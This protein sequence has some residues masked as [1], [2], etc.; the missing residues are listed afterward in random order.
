[1]GLI[2][3]AERARAERDAT[4]VDTSADM[5]RLELMGLSRRLTEESGVSDLPPT[6]VSQAAADHASTKVIN[7]NA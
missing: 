4:A 1:M 5:V 3:R 7:S 6:L 2:F